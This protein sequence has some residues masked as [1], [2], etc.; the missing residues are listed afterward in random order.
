MKFDVAK[1]AGVLSACSFTHYLFQ[2][3][4]NFN[5]LIDFSS[6]LQVAAI[7]LG[8]LVFDN[9]KKKLFCILCQSASCHNK[10]LVLHVLSLYYY[11]LR[12]V[13]S[14]ILSRQTKNSTFR[15]C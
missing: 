1:E 6:I 3:Q 12:R 5:H 11:P 7:E 9:L 2:S 4:I 15:A 10:Y 8:R 14:V 13:A